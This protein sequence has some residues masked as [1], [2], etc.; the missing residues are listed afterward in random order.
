MARCATPSVQHLN[1]THHQGFALMMCFLFIFIYL[2]IYKSYHFLSDS[3]KSDN[4]TIFIG[5]NCF[6]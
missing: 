6:A 1:K 5:Q 3:V 4:L 2:Q